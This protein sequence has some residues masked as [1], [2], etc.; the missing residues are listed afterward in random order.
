MIHKIKILS[1]VLFLFFIFSF[2]LVA[3][4]YHVSLKGNDN[5][6]GSKNN[7]YRTV[8]KGVTLLTAGDSLVVEA[9]NYGYEY[10]I[11]ISNSGTREKPIVVE[12]AERGTVILNGP[13]KPEEVNTY[14]YEDGGTGSC[15]VVSNASHIIIDGFN[16]SNY[17]VGISNGIWGNISN[18]PPKN[19]QIYNCVFHN[20]ASVGIQNYHVDDVLVSNCTFITDEMRQR[21]GWNAIQDYGVN[22]YYCNNCVV[23]NCYFYGEHNQALAFKEGDTSCIARKNVFEGVGHFALFLGQ[24]RLQNES[25]ENKN[26]SCKNLT[27]EYN[28]FRPTNGLNQVEPKRKYRMKTPIVVDNVDSA[29]VRYNYIEG[30]DDG[31]KTCG[32]NIYNE[33][34]GRIEICNNIVAFGVQNLMSG[35]I[36]QDW[37]FENINDVEIHHNTFYRVSTDFINLRHESDQIWHFTKNIAYKTKFYKSNTDIQ[38]NTDN[39]RDDPQFI[40]GDPVQEPINDK[41]VK[42]DF[43]TYY[44]K[45]TSPFHL[46]KDSKAKGYG[47]QFENI[48][49]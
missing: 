5:N 7:P 49:L 11:R 23:E 37:G 39:F 15:F 25:E 19:I 9:G 48:A 41:P 6:N 26:P 18:I 28:I 1:F 13:R 8:K 36:F 45:L 43:E 47:V 35:G 2:S 46:K 33:A 12:A 21:R 42:P 40:N 22:F 32:I 14:Q 38:Y 29:I 4:T 30:F 10:N 44:K 24:N 20:N 27:A 3:K 34:R 16:I 17:T 31:N